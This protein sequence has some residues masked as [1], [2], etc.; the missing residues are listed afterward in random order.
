MF[1][2]MELLVSRSIW[3]FP[4]HSHTV[5][6]RR[7]VVICFACCLFFD[8]IPYGID[9]LLVIQPFEDTVAAN[10]EEVKVW[11][12]FETLYFRLTDYDVRVSSI[13][14]T[15]SFDVSESSRYR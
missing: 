1:I 11:F 2:I 10:E 9:C 13:F 5:S 15:L 8:T 6:L 12:Q 14:G 4:I 3:M 7:K